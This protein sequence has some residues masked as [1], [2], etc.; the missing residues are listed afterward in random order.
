[1]HLGR[2]LGNIVIL[3]RL[4][5]LRLHGTLIDEATNLR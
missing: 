1:M 4:Y 5:L 2:G 3:F